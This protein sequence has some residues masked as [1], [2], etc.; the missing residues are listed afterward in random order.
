MELYNQSTNRQIVAVI[1]ADVLTAISGAMA[2]EL[3]D[4]RI[5]RDNFLPATLLRRRFCPERLALS[6]LLHKL[7]AFGYAEKHHAAA[8]ARF[9]ADRVAAFEPAFGIE[10]RAGAAGSFSR[11]A[12]TA[13]FFFGRSRRVVTDAISRMER[14][15]L[16]N[17][18]EYAGGR[19][20]HLQAPA[21]RRGRPEGYAQRFKLLVESIHLAPRRARESDAA[22]KGGKDL[23][24][25]CREGV[26]QVHR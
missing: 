6:G 25:S 2:V 11:T 14:A 3:H 21:I 18:V 17:V 22:L 19:F 15:F 23:A 26:G 1:F 8:A 16:C 12:A 4:F 9:S 13:F 10:G 20:E 5:D 24:L 7:C